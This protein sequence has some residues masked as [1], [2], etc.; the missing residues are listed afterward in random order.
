MACARHSPRRASTEHPA[1]VLAEHARAVPRRC[2]GAIPF[3][4][5]PPARQRRDTASEPTAPVSS[6]SLFHVGA[7]AVPRRRP[8]AGALPPD[9]V[10]GAV[11]P[12]ALSCDRCA[13]PPRWISPPAALSLPCGGAEGN[14]TRS[15]PGCL[16]PH[17]SAVGS[18][19]A[20]KSTSGRVQSES[21]LPGSRE[22][23]D[24]YERRSHLHRLRQQEDQDLRLQVG[25]PESAQAAG[26]VPRTVGPGV[27]RVR[28]TPGP[29]PRQSRCPP[30]LLTGSGLQR[31]APRSAIAQSAGSPGSADGPCIRTGGT[32]APRSSFFSRW[33]LGGSGCHERGDPRVLPVARSLPRGRGGRKP[34]ACLPPPG[35]GADRPRRAGPT[36]DPL[37]QYGGTARHRRRSTS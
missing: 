1:D 25:L 13:R 26:L 6:V 11:V 28:R 27:R 12:P 4:P 5:P 19:R 3:V 14:R 34:E 29:T 30:G 21:C 20:G 32:P 15:S 8:P 9:V 37:P 31:S 7:W 2:S 23:N 24:R 33:R 36:T 16:P 17:R 22:G 35:P 18:R 10:L